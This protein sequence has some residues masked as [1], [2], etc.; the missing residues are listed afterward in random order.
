VPKFVYVFHKDD[1]DELL[2]LGYQLLKQDEERN[3]FIFANQE[4]QKFEKL[5]MPFVTT[6]IFT[7]D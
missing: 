2:A 3:I 4:V 7:F 5:K 6:D 1:R